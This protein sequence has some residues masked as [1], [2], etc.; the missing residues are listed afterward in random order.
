MPVEEGH[1][2]RRQILDGARRIFMELGFDA[3]SMGE[4]AKAAGVSKG[5][6]YVYF[7]DKNALFVALIEQIA[8]EQGQLAFEAV[9]EGS[10]D[11]RAT[12]Q[13]FGRNYIAFLCRPEGGS[14]I[15][16]V[17]A[18]AER[19][20]ELGHRFYSEVI[21]KTHHRV[22]EYLS[23]EVEAGRLRIPDC[24]LA[25]SQFL[26]ACQATLFLP[27]LFQAPVALAPDNIER[28]VDS[29]VDVFMDAYGV[30]DPR[31]QGRQ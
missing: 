29:A 27:Y 18:I 24:Q 20:P 21:E 14:A 12:L 10:S 1:A 31:N 17:I 9:L 25:G 6:L 4:I 7:S 22:G 28:V 2:K 23:K 8:R 13:R 5:T 11:T 3:A 26:L 15:R 19:M 16:T 30:A